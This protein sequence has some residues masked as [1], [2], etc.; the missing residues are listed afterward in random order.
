MPGAFFGVLNLF[1]LVDRFPLFGPA[2]PGR[3]SWMLGRN[4]P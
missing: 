2:Y 4:N 3:L 1:G